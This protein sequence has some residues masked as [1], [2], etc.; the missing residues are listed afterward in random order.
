M[1]YIKYKRPSLAG[2]TLVMAI[3]LAPTIM[4][5]R[6][7]CCSQVLHEDL[8]LCCTARNGTGQAFVHVAARH[9][10]VSFLQAFERALR[11]AFA[12]R[13]KDY[14]ELKRCDPCMTAPNSCSA[15]APSQRSQR[16]TDN[17]LCRCARAL[18]DRSHSRTGPPLHRQPAGEAATQRTSN[19]TIPTVMLYF[20]SRA[21]LAAG[22]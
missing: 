12:V 1:L 17:S 15:P 2:L 18:Q 10:H 13:S 6:P 22:L 16:S 4:T 14:Q 3:S 19:G 9:G 5:R 20:V 7:A 11:D 8:A 21:G